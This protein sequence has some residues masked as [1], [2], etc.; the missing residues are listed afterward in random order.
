EINR[1]V[2]NLSPVSHGV[3]AAI[4]IATAVL[5]ILISLFSNVIAASITNPLKLLTLAARMIGEGDMAALNAADAQHEGGKMAQQLKTLQNQ[6]NDEVS[7]LAGVFNRLV[8][9]QM[10]IVDTAGR[11]A[12]GDLTQS[13][14][15][16]SERDLLGGA[17]E[18]TI[19]NLRQLTGM[20][21]DNASEL[22]R[23]SIELAR[24][25][26]HSG[27]ATEQIANTMQ[28]IAA[29]VAQQA[30]G[31]NHA[32][33]AFD[34]MKQSFS[35][36]ARGSGV[37]A[38]AVSKDVEMST[39]IKSAILKVSEKSLSQVNGAR[40]AAQAARE[41]AQVAE[42][43]VGGMQQIRSS[44]NEATGKVKEMGQMS[45]QIGNIITVIDDIASQTNLLALNA[46]IEA[47]RAG[48]QGKG[49][50]VV[51]DEVRKL[52]E[53]SSNSTR[54]IS[55]LIHNIQQIIE[56]AVKAMEKSAREV[57]NGVNLALSS[58]QSL[59]T[60]LQLSE[61][62]RSGGDE[63]ATLA[64]KMN[65][66]AVELAQAMQT[67]SKVVQENNVE[68]RRVEQGAGIVGTSMETIAAVSEENSAAVEEVSASA[69]ELRSEMS[70]VA[71]SAKKLE[72]MAADLNQLVLRFKL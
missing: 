20:I 23:F 50:A 56:D 40:Q 14:Q 55:N 42:N 24:S 2:G 33:E 46:A 53:K 48:E 72:G 5:L 15:A 7:I 66:L 67:V 32:G 71:A 36:V 69:E 68:T 52:A 63:I 9:Y 8:D 54:E 21:K 64:Q 38:E 6:S 70:E 43:T 29:G 22:N 60:V 51:A 26:E 17:L 30:E 28:Q 45:Q 49:F 1:R 4:V 25:A 57:E 65:D 16:R 35:G 44:V 18:R 59:N 19:H 11:L 47:A 62:S 3:E 31:I 12:N 61:E 13:I 34:R 27:V 37:Q 10:E 41:G 39:Q 58:R